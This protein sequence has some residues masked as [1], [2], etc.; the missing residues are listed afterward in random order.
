LT[1]PTRLISPTGTS[2]PHAASPHSL[3]LLWML[4]LLLLL[5]LLWLLLL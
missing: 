3:L 5:L 1:T 2:I 4:W